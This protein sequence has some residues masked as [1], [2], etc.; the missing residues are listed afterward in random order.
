MDHEL[1]FVLD[2]V[3][4]WLRLRWNLWLQQPELGYSVYTYPYTRGVSRVYPT[5]TSVYT[6]TPTTG[7][8]Y[9]VYPIFD[10]ETHPR[11]NLR[12]DL[13]IYLNLE[14]VWILRFMMSV[15][16]VSRLTM[17]SKQ[18]EYHPGHQ[19]GPR[20]Q[21]QNHELYIDS[22]TINSDL[23]RHFSA[24]N[25]IN[26]LSENERDPE[27]LKVYFQLMLGRA[28]SGLMFCIK[29]SRFFIQNQSRLR[30]LLEG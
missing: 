8:L 2:F 21:K 20:F 16:A 7:T 26:F 1:G 13:Q 15:W 24:K 29:L 3:L 10:R 19:I 22:I 4:Y 28:G 17:V 6:P 5:P 11:S 30:N 9:E 27:I 14:N 23:L 18:F 12:F 25:I